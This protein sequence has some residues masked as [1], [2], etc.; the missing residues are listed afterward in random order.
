MSYSS[1][2]QSSVDKSMRS[3]FV[4]NIPYRA[5]EENL[6]DIFG[7]VGQIMSLKLVYDRE[8]GRPRGFGFIEYKDQQT[9]LKAIQNLNGFE[10]GGRVLRVDN[11]STQK[12]RPDMR[13]RNE[14]D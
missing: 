6:R 7:D 14:Y 4:G 3:V 10:I 9:A 8:T 5:T 1:A 13:S 11:A 2:D 12:S